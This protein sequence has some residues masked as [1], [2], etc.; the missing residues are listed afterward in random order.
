MTMTT[1]RM[2]SLLPLLALLLGGCGEGLLGEEGLEELTGWNDVDL[3]TAPAWSVRWMLADGWV[4]GD[5]VKVDS[6]DVYMLYEE[7][8]ED[9]WYEYVDYLE[10]TAPEVALPPADAIR[11]A[12]AFTFAVGLPLLLD[13]RDADGDWTPPDHEEWNE[14]W[15]ASAMSAF[16]YADGDLDHLGDSLPVGLDMMSDE[17]ECVLEIEEG[18]QLTM[19]EI[20]VLGQWWDLVE[21]E[22]EDE[23]GDEDDEWDMTVLWPDHE[24]VLTTDHEGALAVDAVEGLDEWFDGGIEALLGEAWW[25]W[26]PGEMEAG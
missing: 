12:E 26:F 15:G 8:A 9:T 5:P 7:E 4:D 17:C 21:G 2:A 1:P 6:E 25:T 23:E 3:P 19:I 13:D 22:E 11:T 20:D 18:T 24:T 14:L 16:L 10:V